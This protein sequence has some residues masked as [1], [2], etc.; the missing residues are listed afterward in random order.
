MA[1]P[2]VDLRGNYYM[3][4][5]MYAVV[6]L[7]RRLKLSGVRVYAGKCRY[8]DIEWFSF[9]FVREACTLALGKCRVV[10]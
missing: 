7:S 2:Y 9:G 3:G 10:M 1:H 6:T 5:S 8:S 4:S